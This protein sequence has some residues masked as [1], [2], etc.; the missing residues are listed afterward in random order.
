MGTRSPA[1]R[2][3]LRVPTRRTD[4]A[5]ILNNASLVN[6]FATRRMRHY[7]YK[8]RLQQEKPPTPISRRL[9]TVCKYRTRHTVS[10]GSSSNGLPLAG[11][12]RIRGSAARRG[13]SVLS[14]TPGEGSSGCCRTATLAGR[15]G[16]GTLAD[17]LPALGSCPRREKMVGAAG[18]PASTDTH[19]SVAPS[20]EQGEGVKN[21]RGIDTFQAGISYN[22]PVPAGG[23]AIRRKPG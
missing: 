23:L 20:S 3:R 2:Q 17:A 12:C 7:V 18:R 4:S 13:G 11:G 22:F 19:I 1:W 16:T 15:T 10:R 5:Y 9:P 6:R 21:F 8:S 14:R